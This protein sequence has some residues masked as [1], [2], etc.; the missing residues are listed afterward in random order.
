MYLSREEEKMLNGE[1]GYAKQVAMEILVALG[2]IYNAEKMISIKSAQTSGVSYKNLGEAGVEWIEELAR[3]GRVEVYTTLN[4]AGMDIE[5]WEEMGI[6]R[7]F[8]EKQIRIINA[9]TKMGIQPTLTCTPYLAGNKPN[10]GDHIAWSES[11]AVIYANSVLGARTNREGGPSALAS[12]LTGRTPYYGLHVSENR[13]HSVKI[14]APDL[15]DEYDFALLGYVS[16]KL[17]KGRIPSFTGIESANQVELKA[18]GAALASTGGVAMFHIEGLTPEYAPSPIDRIEVIDLEKEDLK[19][20]AEELNDGV[21]PELIF[22]GCPHA[23]L[24]ELIMVLER[25]KG[26]TV[27]KK[28]WICV[29]RTVKELSVKL[30]IFQKLEELGVKVF[31]DTCPIVAPTTSLGIGSIATNSAKCGWYSR[32]LNNLK[33]KI[34]RLT[35]LIEEATRECF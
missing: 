10:L 4:P 13:T 9:Y 3:D 17:S 28:T 5:R 22:I 6:S 31:C 15:H 19:N 21:E 1:F 35:D 29:S 12:A 25:L 34:A 14:N 11:S 20:A 16:G 33:I 24:E 30:G 23:S 26:R 18:L 7:D 8:A 2:E 32:N 27:K